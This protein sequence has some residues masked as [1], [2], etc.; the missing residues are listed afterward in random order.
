MYVWNHKLNKEEQQRTVTV[1]AYIKGTSSLGKT[2]LIHIGF[3]LNGPRRGCR[4]SSAFSQSRG[5]PSEC[6]NFQLRLKNKI[7]NYS[8]Y[9]GFKLFIHVISKVVNKLRE[10]A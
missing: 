7:K 2:T 6:N 3:N 1:R 8:P 4:L 5:W 9:E 10:I